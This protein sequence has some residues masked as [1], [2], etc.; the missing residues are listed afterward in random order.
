MLPGLLETWPGLGLAPVYSLQ[1]SVSMH[2]LALVTLFS[3]ALSVLWLCI[4]VL[5][6]SC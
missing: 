5:S 4:W 1:M 2:A 6:V 3:S